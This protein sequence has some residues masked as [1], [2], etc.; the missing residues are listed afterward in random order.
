MAIPLQ[1]GLKLVA[2]DT[3]PRTP[4]GGFKQGRWE[5]MARRELIAQGYDNPEDEQVRVVAENV[6]R[7]ARRNRG[8]IALLGV[9]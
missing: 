1:C 5:E 4:S 8:R 7:H 3:W 2:N 6:A 9:A